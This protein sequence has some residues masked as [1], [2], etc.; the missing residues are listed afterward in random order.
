MVVPDHEDLFGAWA[1]GPAHPGPGAGESACP[2]R[3]SAAGPGAGELACP[4]ARGGGWAV[5]RR[6]AER[7]GVRAQASAPIA[8]VLAEL[9]EEAQSTVLLS[10]DGEAFPH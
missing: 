10:G 6:L 8:A 4:N 3:T 7:S 5:R 2:K 1:P 9:R